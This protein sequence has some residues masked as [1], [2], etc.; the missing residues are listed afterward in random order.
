MNSV[1]ANVKVGIYFSPFARVIF[2]LIW[3]DKWGPISV[4]WMPMGHVNPGAEFK[5]CSYIS[6]KLSIQTRL[7]LFLSH[8]VDT[9]FQGLVHM[10]VFNYDMQNS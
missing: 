10:K 9:Y 4:V 7:K 5:K 2:S 3:R 6:L 8:F 1:W